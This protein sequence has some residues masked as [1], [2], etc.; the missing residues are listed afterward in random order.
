MADDQVDVNLR[1]T[2]TDETG[3]ITQDMVRRAQ[4]GTRAIEAAYQTRARAIEAMAKRAGVSMEDMS[5][6]VDNANKK[7]GMS[8]DEMGKKMSA[9]VADQLQKQQMLG[10]VTDKTTE[11]MK[12]QN[13]A[14][15]DIAKGMSS[16]GKA[17]LEASRASERIVKGMSEAG[18]ATR[19][20]ADEIKKFIEAA[21]GAPPPINRLN[22]ALTQGIGAL[23]RYGAA[24][25][26][27]RAVF[28]G[29]TE[30][31]SNFAERQRGLT[32]VGDAWQMNAKQVEEYK[33]VSKGLFALTGIGYKTL[34]EG[35]RQ[36]AG[37]TKLSHAEALAGWKQIVEF[38]HAYGI[39]L[40]ESIR[41]GN[42][43]LRSQNGNLEGMRKTMEGLLN[44]PPALADAFAQG[45]SKIAPTF[46]SMGLDSQ[47]MSAQYA[48]SLQEIAK[49][50]D[51]PN[52]AA[53]ALN[54]IHQAGLEPNTRMG[55]A[56]AQSQR[57]LAAGQIDSIT[58]QERYYENAKKMGA[59]E[60]DPVLRA[61]RRAAIGADPDALRASE[62]GA[63]ARQKIRE[64]EQKQIEAQNAKNSAIQQKNEQLAKDALGKQQE[65]NQ[66]QTDA[67]LRVGEQVE[68]TGVTQGLITV[69][70]KLDDLETYLKNLFG[71]GGGGDTPP[72]G[73]TPSISQP[74]VPRRRI[75]GAPPPPPPIP[76]RAR[77]GPVDKDKPYLTGEEG[78]E[79][80]VPQTG[81]QVL[82]AAESQRYGDILGKSQAEA[83][84]AMRNY[85]AQFRDKGR[86]GQKF[87]MLEPGGDKKTGTGAGAGS[88]MGTGGPPGGGDGKTPGGDGDGKKTPPTTPD[89]GT[90]AG[91]PTSGPGYNIGP[92]GQ[93]MP[94][95]GTHVTEGEDWGGGT[96]GGVAGGVPGL[97]GSPSGRALTK[98]ERAAG[99]AAPAGTGAGTGGAGGNTV[100]AAQRERFRKE[101]ESNPA[102][103]A[104]VLAIAAGEH[105]NNDAN[106]SVIES[107]MNRAAM[108][109]TTL[110]YEM[111]LTKEGG[112]YA[113]YDPKALN[114]PAYKKQAEA[115]L[116]RALGGSNVSDYAT[117]NASGA[118][119][120]KRM[121]GGMFT[122]VSE[123]GGPHPELF[124]IPTGPGARGVNRYK[125][126]RAAAEKGATPNVPGAP[127]VAGG[128]GG[129][130]TTSNSGGVASP[131]SGTLWQGMGA[132][133]TSYGNR[134]AGPHQGFD[135]GAPIG[136]PIYAEGE[137]VVT[138]E[139]NYQ[140]GSVGGIVTITYKDGT[141]AKYMHL[142]KWDYVKK[143]QT[144]KAGDVIG[145]SGY[146]PAAKSAGNH[147]H[148]EYFDKD[149]KRI[150]PA[151]RH[152]W[153]KTD[154][155]G[156]GLHGRV[157]FAGLPGSF[158]KGTT[159]EAAEAAIKAGGGKVVVAG[160]GVPGVTPPVAPVV[161]KFVPG[162]TQ[163]LPGSQSGPAVKRPKGPDA[164]TPTTPDATPDTAAPAITKGKAAAGDT[165]PTSKA[166]TVS[167][168]DDEGLAEGG[169]ATAGHEYW[170]G[171]KGPEKIRMGGQSGKVTTAKRAQQALKELQ[172]DDWETRKL[173]AIELGNRRQPRGFSEFEN[174]P[175]IPVWGGGT[176]PSPGRLP[177]VEQEYEE[178][179][180]KYKGDYDRE[181][182]QDKERYGPNYSPGD[183]FNS[184]TGAP[185]GTQINELR[186]Q[187]ERP[188]EPVI[189][190]K[191]QYLG[192][193]TA[194][195]SRHSERQRQID[196]SRDYARK[197][198]T[199]AGFA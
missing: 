90:P 92:Y 151:V 168:G 147:L 166:T 46:K 115:N 2:A 198:H 156:E 9:M 116:E 57:E 13:Q 177:R 64:N 107:A 60:A 193:T 135:V 192:G 53:A 30:S 169:T 119:G 83:D 197:S 69:N 145:G 54:K 11:A 6:R 159:R 131:I 179:L 138:V 26:T 42:T 38:S 70:K 24:A 1:F 80:V 123:H 104:K 41:I 8:F 126:W 62:A 144:V 63:Q 140:E 36:W 21:G 35:A 113:G 31:Y 68:A 43:A 172:A 184:R 150:D 132:P 143:G 65:L 66:L 17:T 165:A 82:T 51:D 27:T 22:T 12:R 19:S 101:L 112:Y 174:A 79:I 29:L 146:S 188:I 176:K 125:A 170:V 167:A 129:A 25:A 32:R 102:L 76:G 149:G 171:E 7:T 93:P 55:R 47:K 58:F 50:Y 87:A 75:R 117:E 5:K 152:G 39:G 110:A 196:I 44:L 18:R 28:N 89:T 194:R 158:P 175:E 191:M 181:G 128:G 189:R 84:M 142:S 37:T 157:T 56:M 16:L 67:G 154:A 161:P 162:R 141:K 186:A 106:T 105:K 122:K 98:E 164:P 173:K 114:N 180:R 103:R 155:K 48:A 23:G 52:E 4:E 153:G 15:V 49:S 118:W 81:G 178:S 121:S 111:R 183:Q 85:F 134:K 99:G 14:T 163:G 130:I 190:P 3:R 40:Q 97:P 199:D 72:G 136:T 20:S 148:V 137:G 45:Y 86:A 78:P 74:L 195:W 185:I 133:R 34:D 187:M 139:P 91:P 94:A 127:P 100:L 77:G 73:A 33:E 124:G 71:G 160:P 10:G 95:W 120:R 108:M 109:N 182:W 88:G 59:F 96:G 61:R